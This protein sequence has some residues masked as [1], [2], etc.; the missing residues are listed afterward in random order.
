MKILCSLHKCTYMRGIIWYKYAALMLSNGITVCVF[1]YFEGLPLCKLAVGLWVCAYLCEQAINTYMQSV[2]LLLCPQMPQPKNRRT[3][4]NWMMV[5]SKATEN[6][7]A[8]RSTLAFVI[9][10][11]A[12]QL[13]QLIEVIIIRR[14]TTTPTSTSTSTR[15]VAIAITIHFRNVIF[16]VQ[17]LKRINSRFYVC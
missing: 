13:L 11:R 8:M 10:Q 2:S 9:T 15:T 12:V 4:T 1:L 16:V 14:V 6:T 7:W 5:G 17:A 3:K